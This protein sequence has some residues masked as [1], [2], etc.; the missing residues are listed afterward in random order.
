LVHTNDLGSLD[1]AVVAIDD[2]GGLVAEARHLCDAAN[3]RGAAIPPKLGYQL[4]EA[5]S[6]FTSSLQRATMV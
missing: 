6:L 4:D 2:N 5:P 3:L 1:M